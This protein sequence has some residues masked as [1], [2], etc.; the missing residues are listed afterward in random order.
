MNEDITLGEIHRIVTEIRADVK[1]QNGRVN[2]HDTDIAVVQ[3]RLR[4]ITEDMESV[5]E[6]GKKWGAGTG[7]IAGG[8]VSGLIY[9]LTQMFGGG[10]K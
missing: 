10:H 6:S 3:E 1:M 9:G 2:S 4:S 7:A 8:F 5:T